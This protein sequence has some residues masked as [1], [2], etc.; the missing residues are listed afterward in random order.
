MIM[1][2]AVSFVIPTWNRLHEIKRLIASIFSQRCKHYEII[3]VENDSTDGTIEYLDSLGD[4]IILIKN[5]K[6]MGVSYAK[7]QG[8]AASN[9]DLVWFLDSDSE[10]YDPETL[11]RSLDI[12]N[13]HP[14]IGSIGGEMNLDRNGDIFYRGKMNK[15]NGETSN[16]I[17]RD[18]HPEMLENDY[19]PTCNCLVRKDLLYR[20][21]GFDPGYFFLYE[22]TELGFAIKKMGFQ[23]I[24]DSRVTVIHH[25]TEQSRAS[26]LFLKNR[27]RLRF[28]LLNENLKKLML[29]PFYEIRGLVSKNEIIAI[30]NAKDN[31]HVAKYMHRW[32]LRVTEIRPWCTPLVLLLTG[33]EYLIS[34]IFA[35]CFH[36]IVL[37]RTIFLRRNRPG[38]LT[39][40]DFMRE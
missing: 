9:A 10:L 7:N 13:A 1:V 20:W 36:L 32:A 40:L 18:S 14:T 17:Y 15:T 34:I 30:S 38:F 19:L 11:S 29:L 16:I 2:P 12:I 3:I 21:G 22:D 35:Y 27:N 8:I 39:A 28:M 5:G 24:I 25:I 23:N 37:P 4:A 31:P 33:A 26:N 6:N